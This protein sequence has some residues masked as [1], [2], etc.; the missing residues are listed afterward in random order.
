MNP[1]LFLAVAFAAAAIGPAATAEPIAACVPVAAHAAT[2]LIERGPAIG[3]VY[4]SGRPFLWGPRD[5]RFEV[6]VFGPQTYVYGVDV[7]L[8]DACK[9]VA[10]NSWLEN[11]PYGNHW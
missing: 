7:T 6:D 1:V 9:V 10:I 8:D 3:Q 2:T 5:L 11:N 4:V